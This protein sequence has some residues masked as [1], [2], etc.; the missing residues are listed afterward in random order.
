[1]TGSACPPKTAAWWARRAKS[2]SL[3]TNLPRVGDASL[4]Q[5]GAGG[6]V[7]Q[8][9]QERT[10][11]P[12]RYRRRSRSR[13]GSD[14]DGGCGSCFGVLLGDLDDGAMHDLVNM[15]ASHRGRLT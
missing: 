11:D 8:V 10:V 13:R 1:M 6:V 4:E 7:D 2:A 12:E 14:A 15:Q 3:P 5:D 9:E